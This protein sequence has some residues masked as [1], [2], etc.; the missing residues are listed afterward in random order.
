MMLSNFEETIYKLESNFFGSLIV[1]MMDGGICSQMYQYLI[2]QIMK[3]QGYKVKYDIEWFNNYAKDMNGIYSRNFDL[4]KAFPYLEFEAASPLEIH[5]YKK[6]FYYEEPEGL[7]ENFRKQ[8]PPVYFGG[9]YNLV[10]IT[11]NVLQKYFVFSNNL[12]DKK[13]QLIADELNTQEN[14]VGVHV[15]R[16][17]MA[18]SG[19]YWDVLQP[20]YFLNSIQ[21]MRSQIANPSFY[22]FS[23]EPD[24]VKDEIISKLDNSIPAKIVGLNGSDKGYIDLFLCSKCKHQISSQG[25][26]GKYGGILNKNPN[27]IVI[28]NS[29]SKENIRTKRLTYVKLLNN[30]GKPF[31]D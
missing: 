13:N 16:G 7:E 3:E 8:K 14:S 27:K 25:S 21:Y 1:V 24:W 12:L 31:V 26:I 5:F 19:Y 9:Y 11:D 29:K 18:Q 6:Y 30:S 20:E 17:D 2:G 28:I 22:F 10:D 23:D 4:L 15:R